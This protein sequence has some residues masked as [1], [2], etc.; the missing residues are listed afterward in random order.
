MN[1]RLA[2]HDCG[3]RAEQAQGR[4]YLQQ[5]TKKS[6]QRLASLCGIFLCPGL[7]AGGLQIWSA[8]ESVSPCAKA[9]QAVRITCRSR[10]TG[11]RS[12]KNLLAFYPLFSIFTLLRSVRSVSTRNTRGCEVSALVG[13][14]G[15]RG[16]ESVSPRLRRARPYHPESLRAREGRN[17][18]W[19]ELAL[20]KVGADRK[21]ALLRCDSKDMDSPGGAEG[22][23]LLTAFGAERRLKS[24]RGRSAQS[25]LTRSGH[26]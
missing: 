23:Q 19:A 2:L 11:V 10:L 3:C 13:F 4:R 9:Q 14:G 12:A 20:L 21:S 24:R 6:P 16:L 22:E 7:T 17:L 5:T 8:L 18:F 1:L 26:T 15:L 25:R